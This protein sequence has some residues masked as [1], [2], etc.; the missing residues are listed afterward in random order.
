MT[1][2]GP[3]QV[4]TRRFALDVVRLSERFPNSRTGDVFARQLL[5]AGTSVAANYRAAC[6]AKSAADFISKMGTVEEEADEAMFWLEIAHELG[7]ATPAELSPLMA[8]ANQLVA[9]TV[10]SV[11]TTRGSRARK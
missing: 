1:A 7:L 4:R 8:E 11:R 10:A 6:R 9:M 3:L 2:A 5:R